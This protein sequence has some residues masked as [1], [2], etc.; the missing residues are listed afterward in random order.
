MDRAI[1]SDF[2]CT[3]GISI[4]KYA[5]NVPKKNEADGNG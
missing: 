4:S 2:N 5:S 3:F 1:V